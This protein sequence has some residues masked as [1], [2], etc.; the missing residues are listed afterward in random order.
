[1]TT[2]PRRRTPG[3]GGGRPVWRVL[4]ITADPIFRQ[5]C[6]PTLEQAGFVVFLVDSGITAV[7]A[8]RDRPP[9]A[10]IMDF[11]LPDVPWR[12]ALCWLR[13]NPALRATPVALLTTND[14]GA[15]DG[16]EGHMLLHLPRPASAETILHGMALLQAQAVRPARA[17]LSGC[18]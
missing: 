6:V 10:I 1:M 7:A 15:A 2:T 11:L 16:M 9:D 4:V 13:S 18:H 5:L 14:A 12:V 8:A 17:H 3:R